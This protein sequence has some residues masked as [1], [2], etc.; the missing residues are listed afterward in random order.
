M[1]NL[2]VTKPSPTDCPWGV[3]TGRL[4]EQGLPDEA[5][6]ARARWRRATTPGNEYRGEDFQPPFGDPSLEQPRGVLT[7]KAPRP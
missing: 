2:A 3:Y 4:D 1:A 5:A 7:P 6:H